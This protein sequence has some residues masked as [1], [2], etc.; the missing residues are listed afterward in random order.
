MKFKLLI[1]ISTFFF[2]TTNAIA[3]DFPN[4]GDYRGIIETCLAPGNGASP[5]SSSSSERTDNRIYSGLIWELGAKSFVPDFVIGFRSL[6]VKSS[7]NVDGGDLSVR[8]KYDKGLEFDSTRLV[9]VG[10]KRDVMGNVGGGYSFSENS[11][12]ATAA[13]QTSNFRVGSDYLIQKRGFKP[14]LEINTLNKPSE[15]KRKVVAGSSLC[16]NG[17]RPLEG[18]ENFPDPV[19]G[20]LVDQSFGTIL[21][22][23][24]LTCVPDNFVPQ[25]GM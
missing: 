16:A 9:Y 14:Y 12:L 23:S 17:Y 24:D 22:E 6:K 18:Q 20:L 19:T 10:G 4:C 3:N 2:L 15:E 25:F 8:I 11:L 1:S 13:I 5:S 21:N 7:D